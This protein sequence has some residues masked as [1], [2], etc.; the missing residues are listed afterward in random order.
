MSLHRGAVRWLVDKG[1][2]AVRLWAQ[3][4]EEGVSRH[5]RLS[6]A[7]RLG[8]LPS[9]GG[10]GMFKNK[11]VPNKMIK[12]VAYVK[13]LTKEGINPPNNE[14]IIAASETVRDPIPE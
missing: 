13:Y 7:R 11:D 9:L 4:E 6:D 5:H 14:N 12:L 3:E 8:P 1:L 10:L 2:C